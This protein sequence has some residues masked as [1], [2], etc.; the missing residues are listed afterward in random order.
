MY[1]AGWRKNDSHEIHRHCPYFNKFPVM[2]KRKL[3]VESRRMLTNGLCFMRCTWNGFRKKTFHLIKIQSKTCLRLKVITQDYDGR[4][5]NV[6]WML[7]FSSMFDMKIGPLALL[8]LGILFRNKT[9]KSP[10][11][12]ITLFQRPSNVHN[13]QITLDESWNNVVC[14]LGWL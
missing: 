2:F 9:K 3:W 1:H 12:H 6:K 5:L 8:S 10:S 11:Y 7:I 14:Q 4:K 13:V